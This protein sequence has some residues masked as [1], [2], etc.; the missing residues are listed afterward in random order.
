MKKYYF[1][2]P[3]QTVPE[4]I[5]FW[6]YHSEE[7]EPVEKVLSKKQNQ[8]GEHIP[9]QFYDSMNWKKHTLTHFGIESDDDLGEGGMTQEQALDFIS[10]Q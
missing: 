10:K 8:Q 7:S 2:T 3:D 5:L 9:L 4:G 1:F 6:V